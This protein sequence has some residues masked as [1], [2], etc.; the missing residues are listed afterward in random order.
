MLGG[1][2]ARGDTKCDI[3][4]GHVCDSPRSGICTKIPSMKIYFAFASALL[5]QWICAAFL[6]AQTPDVVSAI[7]EVT[8][9]R[10][11]ALVKRTGRLTLA[12]GNQA[13]A[14][15]QLAQGIRPNT[16]QLA[17]GRGVSV[18]ALDVSQDPLAAPA[19]PDSL[20]SLR[21]LLARVDDS[22]AII[23][24]ERAGLNEELAVLAA[25]RDLT[26]EDATPA[27]SATAI[28]EAA[29]LYRELTRE[30]NVALARLLPRE[31]DLTERQQRLQR[32][33][34]AIRPQPR[35][36]VGRV[37][38]KL[39]AERAGT[40]DFELS[41]IVNNASWAPDYDLYVATENGV[42]ADL[43]LAAKVQQY[44]G[45]DWSDVDITFST[46]D[47][48]SRLQAPELAPL[49]L[50]RDQVSLASQVAGNTA[51]MAM[52]K[53]EQPEADIAY[54]QEEI[55]MDG[56][57]APRR[58]AAAM[59]TFSTASNS[60]TARLYTVERPFSLQPNGQPSSVRLTR[61]E[62]PLSLR[63]HIVPKRESTAYLEGLATGWDT[64]NLLAADLR[65]HLDDRYLGATYLDPA[66]ESDTL[67][68]G[69][70]PDPRI[71][72]ERDPLG[73]G[74]DKKVLRNRVHYDLGYRITLRN[75][76]D[77][78]VSVL[79]E[80][81]VP[82]S[83]RDEVEVDVKSI[84]NGGQ[85]EAETGEVKWQ[86]SLKPA[87]REELAVRYEVE[88]PKGVRVSFE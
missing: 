43:V 31:R 21:S 53:N 25:N 58:P 83:Q 85:L 56:V 67:S 54:L 35:G 11:G 84:S 12:A 62:L 40:Y 49:Y 33:V 7:T 13:V 57:Q 59:T 64:L 29:A 14:F 37:S 46:S 9:Y 44:T 22:L 71:V 16:V 10:Q 68:F 72:V 34:S 81:Q 42:R 17:V 45:V 69:L 50:G 82:V 6:P 24:A 88:A 3:Y 30:A 27:N 2:H 87:G 5:T 19:E 32:R 18:F 23:A 36:D 75:T 39:I 1:R 15:T 74:S 48:N 80:D 73:T 47:I 55:L 77:V 61:S 41:Y 66:Q 52:R 76:R 20:V 86:L 8:V 79:V 38:A 4:G 63:Y 65:L 51:G 60:A 78:P 28:R 70:G 26:G